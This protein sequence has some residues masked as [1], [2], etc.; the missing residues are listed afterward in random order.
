M[1]NAPPKLNLIV[2]NNTF[3]INQGLTKHARLTQKCDKELLLFK[4]K[5]KLSTF[6][7]EFM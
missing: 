6:Y 3:F 4:K 1:I 2:V 7:I 5:K